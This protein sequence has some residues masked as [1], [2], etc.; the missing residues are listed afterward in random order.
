LPKPPK[1]PSAFRTNVRSESEVRR[2]LRDGINWTI[3]AND[4]DVFELRRMVRAAVLGNAVLTITDSDELNA[5][6]VRH[7]ARVGKQNVVFR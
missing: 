6:D 2:I 7:I 5:F 3:S 4:Y 1:I